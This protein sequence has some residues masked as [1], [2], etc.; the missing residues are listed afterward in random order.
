MNYFA[1]ISKYTQFFT[2]RKKQESNKN[3]IQSM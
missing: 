1:F 3:N 2:V